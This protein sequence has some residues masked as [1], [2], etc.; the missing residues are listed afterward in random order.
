M[1][2]CCTAILIFSFLLLSNSIKS[3]PSLSD[4]IFH[5]DSL[6]LFIKILASDSMNGRF[7]GTKE[8]R[9]AA[10]FIAKHFE[11]T[12]IA[13]VAGNIRYFN[14]IKTGWFNVVGAIK[15]KSKP[16]EVIIFSAHYDHIGTKKTNP[17][18]GMGGNAKAEKG[19]EIFNGANDNASGVC[20]IISLAKYFKALDN[21]ERTLIFI[22]F[23]GEEQGLIGSK[24]FAENIEPDSVIAVINIE[25]IG[26]SDAT[27]PRPYIT[28]SEYSDLIDI[29]NKNY[30]S[31]FDK[32]EKRFFVPDP[33]NG[34]ML[35]IRSDNY[36]FAQKGIPAHSVMLSSPFDRY[37]H[38]LNDEPQT[39]NYK[40]MSKII[41]SIAIAV[42]GLVTGS[43][44]PQRVK[45]F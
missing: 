15:G 42:N 32:K 26:R 10:F 1:K 8:N 43:D 38:N 28:G 17:F 3:Q 40:L 24:Y 39:L 27:K 34:S 22:A 21:N 7:S 12:G 4:S 11:N 23:T 2:Q 36:P 29:L 5:P 35:F 20:A 6:R 45:G 13:P 37:Y 19:D 31:L 44:T 30:H 9:Q 18:P 14:E 33:Y 25:M 41:K 16:G